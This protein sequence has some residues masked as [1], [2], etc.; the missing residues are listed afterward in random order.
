MESIED[1]LSFV[2]PEIPPLDFSPYAFDRDTLDGL[3]NQP[4][5]YW[6]KDRSGTVIYVGKAKNLRSRVHSYFR[7]TEYRTEK[8]QRILEM[9]YDLDYELVGSEL[10]ALLLEARRIRQHRP[11]INVQLQIHD[12]PISPAQRI[13]RILILPSR[14]EDQFELFLVHRTRPLRQITLSRSTEDW[15]ELHALIDATYFAAAREDG[16][17]SDEGRE[18]REILLRWWLRHRDA[19]DGVDMDAV[20]DT[21]DALRL[22]RQYIEVGPT[23]TE[24][25]VYI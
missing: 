11:A 9:L 5:V 19:V 24:R 20:A 12:R 21:D 1:L 2:Y 17:L 4:G 14:A 13:S 22:L 7:R 25:V 6:M 15:S 18:E 3:P 8:V 23:N 16:E 10:E